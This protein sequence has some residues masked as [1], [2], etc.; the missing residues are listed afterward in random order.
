MIDCPRY[1]LNNSNIAMHNWFVNIWHRLIHVHVILTCFCLLW[2]VLNLF[3]NIFFTWCPYGLNA[4]NI[5]RSV[6]FICFGGLFKWCSSLHLK[7]LS[8]HLSFSSSF[9]GKY[10]SLLRFFFMPEPEDPWALA[11]SVK[12]LAVCWSS[13]DGDAI[14]LSSCTIFVSPKYLDFN[15]LIWKEIQYVQSYLKITT[16]IRKRVHVRNDYFLR[17][18]LEVLKKWWMKF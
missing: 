1:C 18:K 12:G 13:S 3:R 16:V 17:Y 11:L 8:C 2:V 5:F 4:L 6:D 10:L 7:S 14:R 15:E 9:L